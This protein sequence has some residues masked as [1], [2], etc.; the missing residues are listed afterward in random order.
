MHVLDNILTGERY[1]PLKQAKPIVRCP[2][3][4]NQTLNTFEVPE[5]QSA[6]VIC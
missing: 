4:F 3:K 1:E 5:S 6:Q 2:M